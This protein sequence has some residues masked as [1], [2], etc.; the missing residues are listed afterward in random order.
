MISKE[1]L[2][3]VLGVEV[4]NL[5]VRENNYIYWIP[6]ERYKNA[7]LI[8]KPINIYEL[9]DKCIRWMVDNFPE[10]E[11]IN[12]GDHFYIN[13]V[14]VSYI[15][16]TYNFQCIVGYRGLDRDGDWADLNKYFDGDALQEVVLKATEWVKKQTKGDR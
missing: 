6:N 15:G 8:Q 9:V 2:S 5:T 12:N 4:V 16:L 13:D 7:P 10:D 11:T 1:V 14:S 3:E